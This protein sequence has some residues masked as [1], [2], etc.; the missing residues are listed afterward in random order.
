MH[1]VPSRCVSEFRVYASPRTLKDFHR[2]SVG[3]IRWDLSPNN[4]ISDRHTVIFGLR[5]L[6]ERTPYFG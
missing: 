2:S 5:T 1:R 3:P 4:P 6:A